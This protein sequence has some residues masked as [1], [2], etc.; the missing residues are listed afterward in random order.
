VN[1][2]EDRLRD[3]YRAAA[4]TV[5][6]DSVPDL[7]D[8]PAPGRARTERAIRDGSR[9]WRRLAI[10]VAAAA[11]VSL[12]ATTVW[13]ARPDG[14]RPN[15]PGGLIGSGTATAPPFIVGVPAGKPSQ[16]AVYSASTGRALAAIPA[17]GS[18]LGFVQ[19]APTSNNRAFIVAVARLHGGCSTQ[20]YRLL[21]TA[22]GRLASMTK[23]DFPAAPT[24]LLDGMAATPDGKTIAWSGGGC[25]GGGH[26]T[27]TVVT[28]HGGSVV[29]R[30]WSLQEEGVADMSL[31]PDGRMLYFLNRLGSGGG[32]IRALR[33]SAKPGPMVRRSRAMGWGGSASLR[34]DGGIAL[35]RGGRVQLVCVVVPGAAILASYNLA[36]SRVHTIHTWRHV[37]A[38]PCAIA[39]TADGKRAL[40]SGI[41]PGIGTRVDLAAGRVQP[42]AGHL[43]SP[44][45]ALSW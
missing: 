28:A 31:S 32:V 20:F 35:A 18:G 27:I 24:A 4:D 17:P 39:T 44:P 3:A 2:I 37:V 16:L 11:A 15:G 40:V 6:P 41:V 43:A 7:A 9:R 19:T 21:L 23:L 38:T 12:I 25:A 10:P 42:I 33:T 45:G 34:Q 13:L 14:T 1:T 5:G 22:D 30:H 29:S 8:R 36:T 26:G